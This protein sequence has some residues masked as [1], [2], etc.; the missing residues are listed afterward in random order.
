[1]ADHAYE[2]GIDWTLEGKREG[3]ESVLKEARSFLLELIEQRFGPVPEEI[4]QRVAAMD[5]IREMVQAAGR[6][7]AATSLEALELP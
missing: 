2:H 5:S 6:I 3:S 1:M 7:P 4:R